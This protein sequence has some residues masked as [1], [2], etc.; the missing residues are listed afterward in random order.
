[1]IALCREQRL[2]H[3]MKHI[4][5]RYFFARELQQYGQLRLA[6]VASRANTVDVFTKDLG[7]SDRQRFCTALGLVPTLPHAPRATPAA[8]DYDAIPA[9]MH[10]LSVNAEG[11]C[12]LCVLPDPDI[13]AAALGASESALPGTA[14]AEALHTFML[15]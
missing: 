12:Y 10:A 2:E 8:L 11:D 1:M 6:Y 14:P 15:D 3:R 13:E 5:L 4:A 7:S 9:A